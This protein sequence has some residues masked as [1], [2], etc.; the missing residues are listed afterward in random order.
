MQHGTNRSHQT[1]AKPVAR[2]TEIAKRSVGT[3][4]VWF[5]VAM[6]RFGTANGR[7]STPQRCFIGLI[8]RLAYRYCAFITWTAIQSPAALS[9]HRRVDI[10][11]ELAKKAH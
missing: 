10:I 5:P 9:D 4:R 6:K 2:R 1:E 11:P 7:E 3:G 8:T